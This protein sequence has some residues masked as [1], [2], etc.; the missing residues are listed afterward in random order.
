MTIDS[1]GE[2]E[3]LVFL[4][5]GPNCRR[6]M[7]EWYDDYRCKAASSKEIKRIRVWGTVGN[8]TDLML[9]WARE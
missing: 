3:V 8:K 1:S 4:F 9:E 6:K 2:T 7:L 5:R